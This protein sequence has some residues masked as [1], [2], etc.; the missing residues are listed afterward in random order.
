[1]PKTVRLR[2]AQASP[3]SSP[4]STGPGTPYKKSAPNL[5]LVVSPVHHPSL[6]VSSAGAQLV[7]VTMGLFGKSTSKQTAK[8]KS[9]VKLTAARL[10]FA[11]RPCLGRRSVAR[12]DVGQLLAIGRLD[13]ALLRVSA[14]DPLLHVAV[15]C[16][17]P[18]RETDTE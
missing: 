8:V 14:Q 1:M 7:S 9:L 3:V 5:P 17:S 10:P 2:G 12:G 15:A 16:P 11:R 6:S 13:R 4:P 18:C